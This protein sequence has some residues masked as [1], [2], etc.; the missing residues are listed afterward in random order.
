MADLA[1]DDPCRPAGEGLEAGLK[2]VILVLDLDGL[3]P[4]G[5][6]GAREGQTALLRLIGGGL[7][8]DLR[9]EQD[10]AGALVIKEDDPLGDPNHIGG[11]DHAL[12]PVGGQGVQQVLDRKTSFRTISRIIC[13]FLLSLVFQ[14]HADE[15]Q[16][17]TKGLD[18]AEGQ[19]VL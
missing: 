12:V 11:H 18:P 13:R 10:P 3:L 7:F 8:Y 4:L 17:Q 16:S 2:A 14:F 5:L 15:P 1:L 9:V 19:G 6:S